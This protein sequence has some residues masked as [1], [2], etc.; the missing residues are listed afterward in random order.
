MPLG[1]VIVT[2]AKAAVKYGPAAKV[3]YD[4]AKEPATDYARKKLEGA[5]NR[6]LA[7][8]KARTLRDGMLLRVMP[9]D[10]P[11][12]VVFSGDEP[13]SAHP[14]SGVPMAELLARADLTKR[15]YPD[16]VPTAK[17]RAVS[18]RDTAIDSVLRR[19]GPRDTGPPDRIG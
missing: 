3:V 16:Q 17:D 11:V 15:I 19:K 7:I 12:W 5:R 10:E 1:R 18:V 4:Q 13:V 14:D 2:A 6:R 8:D 9:R